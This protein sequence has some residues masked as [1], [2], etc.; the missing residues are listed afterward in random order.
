MAQ[1]ADREPFYPRLQ[2]P[3]MSPQRAKK[4]KN[5]EMRLLTA[6][7]KEREAVNRLAELESLHPT[8]H[9]QHSATTLARKIRNQKRVINIAKD[10]TKNARALYHF[11][12]DTPKRLRP[13]QQGVGMRM[14]RCQRYN[15]GFRR[16]QS[17]RGPAEYKEAL[18]SFKHE[19]SELPDSAFALI[20]MKPDKRYK[21]PLMKKYRSYPKIP[22]KTQISSYARAK[23]LGREG[24]ARDVM[25]AAPFVRARRLD[26]DE[27]EMAL[28]RRRKRRKRKLK[29]GVDPKQ[30]KLYWRFSRN[31]TGGGKKSPWSA[32]APKT[33]AE[34]RKIK[35]KC[36]NICFGNP[37]T[38]G[39]PVCTTSSCKPDP[40]GI[41]AARSRAR[42]F[43]HRKG[44]IGSR[45]RAV[46]RK[47]G[48]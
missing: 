5:L 32:V 11:D 19:R 17:G 6:V 12:I 15:R 31:K 24:L 21:P 30:P 26:D 16:L 20:E 8:S 10:V 38:L 42:Q 1:Q 40:R 46:L 43:D 27:K 29:N 39:Y 36:G 13:V 45:A 4:I 35:A 22:R 33:T 25:D 7:R 3:L 18:D 14:G 44:E 47:I 23:Q 48:K 2:Y 37:S 28:P 9:D 34:R 41:E